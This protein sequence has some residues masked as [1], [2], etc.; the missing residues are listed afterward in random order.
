MDRFFVCKKCCKE[1]VE[2]FIPE[3][4]SFSECNPRISNEAPCCPCCKSL[5]VAPKKIGV[6]ETIGVV[7]EI[8]KAQAYLNKAMQLIEP[9]KEAIDN[10]ENMRGKLYEMFDKLT[11]NED[12]DQIVDIDTFFS[13]TEKHETDVIINVATRHIEEGQLCLTK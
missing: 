12:W 1:W 10:L 11:T 8:V 2:E 5:E 3:L 4:N 9:V 6:T 13:F 7:E